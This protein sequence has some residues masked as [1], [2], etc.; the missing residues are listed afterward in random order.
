MTNNNSLITFILLAIAVKALAGDDDQCFG[1]INNA[2][3]GTPSQLWSTDLRSSGAPLP[4]NAFWLNYVL[5]D[6]SQPEYIHPYS[7]RFKQ[8]LVSLCY[9]KRLLQP[10]AVIQVHTDDLSISCKEEPGTAFAVSA[11]D[12]LS[13]T[14][15]SQGRRLTVPLVRGSPY[16][17]FLFRGGTPLLSTINA[18]INVTSNPDATK[19]KILFNSGQTWLLYS[20]SPLPISIDATTSSFALRADARPFT[21]TIR[22]AVLTDPASEPTLD[23]YSQCYATRGTVEFPAPFTMQHKYT[24]AGSTGELLLLSLPMHRSI[25][26][27]AGGTGT[28]AA[29]GMPSLTYNSIDGQME[30]VVGSTWTLRAGGANVSWHSPRGLRAD[31]A[32]AHEISAALQRDVDDLPGV[33]VNS[34]TYFFGKAAARAAR[35]ALIAEEVARPDLTGRIAA[36]LRNSLAQWLD[37]NHAVNPNMSNSIGYDR[38]WGGLVSSDGAA[39]S[40]A[41]FGLGMYNDHHFHWGY[42]VYAGAVLARMD[43]EWGSQHRCQL[44]SLVSDYM[45]HGTSQHNS[46][47]AAR[48]PR[49]RHFDHWLMHSWAAGLKNF[50]DGRN[51]E[52]TSEAVNSYYAASLLGSA[53]HDA[54]LAELGVTLVAFETHAAQSL[55]HVPLGSEL[56]EAEFVARNRMIGV[57]WANKRD[58]ALWFGP[59]EWLEVRLGIQ[60]LPVT[61]VTEVLFS[62]TGFAREVVEW[63]SAAMDSRPEASD[64]WKG[65]VFALQASY[66]P[67][68]ALHHA[69]QLKEFDDGNSA[70]NLLWWIHTRAANRI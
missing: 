51:Q 26:Q 16:V 60:V 52:S 35:L 21:G 32:A 18:V 49:L 56:Y 41:D 70:S 10:T 65:F 53:F 28:N 66:D 58:T 17:T 36:T 3:A 67:A 46:G 43:P 11:F 48:Y 9:P 54:A 22:A 31:P 45:Q 44:Y 69:R 2:A 29:R 27:Q 68:T 8:G 50:A 20:S 57:L 38:Q 39:D 55:W 19:H 25:L 13:V 42:F 59:P 24:T 30:G 15:A 47:S 33:I 6:G 12:D 40:G 63:A 14:L 64:G 23:T 61:P 5:Q 62:D 4:T 34:S 37:S 1:S 7:I